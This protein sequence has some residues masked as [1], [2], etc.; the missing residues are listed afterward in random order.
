MAT[1]VKPAMR[2][3]SPDA[4]DF[5]LVDPARLGGEPVFRGTRVPI[6]TLFEYLRAGDTLDVFLDHFP[7]V[8]RNQAEGVIDLAVRG[9]LATVARP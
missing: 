7:G 3:E 5:V 2:R 9:L 8:G 6:K 1:A 4:N